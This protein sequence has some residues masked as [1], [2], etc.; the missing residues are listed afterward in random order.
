MSPVGHHERDDQFRCVVED[1]AAGHAAFDS[2][3]RFTVAGEI[4]TP[5]VAHPVQQAGSGMRVLHPDEAHGPG[6]VRGGRGER[7]G[8]GSLDQFGCDGFGVELTNR[9]AQQL[10]LAATQRNRFVRAQPEQVLLAGAQQR[11]CV[12]SVVPQ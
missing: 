5:L 9:A 10:G 4:V 3:G 7:L 2:I 1:L 8:H 6:V 11:A 12:G